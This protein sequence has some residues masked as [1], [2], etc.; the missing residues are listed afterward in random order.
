[1]EESGVEDGYRCAGARGVC[2]VVEERRGMM[3]VR[4]K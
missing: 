3:E 4:R 1:M 2:L